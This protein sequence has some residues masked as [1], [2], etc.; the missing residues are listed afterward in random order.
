MRTNRA[1]LLL[2]FAILAVPA[3][4]AAEPIPYSKT[5]QRSCAAD[6]KKYCGEYGLESTALRACMDRNGES[7]SSTCVKALVSDGQI[8]QAEVDRR[9]KAGH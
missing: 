9:K 5:V 3:V 2:A 7:L 1:L 8:S 4:A 6:Y